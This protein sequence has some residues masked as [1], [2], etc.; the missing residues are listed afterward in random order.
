MAVLRR[1]F[2]QH[3]KS[4]SHDEDFYYLCRDSENNEVFIVHEWYYGPDIGEARL[5]V[6]EFI[7]GSKGHSRL[8]RFYNLIGTLATEPEHA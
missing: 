4:G 3:E 8:T 2:Y 7:E 1:R 5:S 6:A